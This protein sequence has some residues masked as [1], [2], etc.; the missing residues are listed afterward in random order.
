M[1]QVIKVLL[2]ED[3]RIEARQTQHWL[4]ATKD[5]AFEVEC[6][7]QLKLGLERLAKGGIDIVLL[8]L[9]L[10][11][12]RG[13]E[14]FEKLYSEVPEVPIVVLTGEYDEAIGPSTVAKGAQDYL[15]KQR[16]DSASLTHVL[17]YALARHQAQQGKLKEAVRG[18]TGRVIGFLGA[19]GG[20]GTTTVALNAA[21]ALAMQDKAVIL[22]ELR[23]SFGTL[24]CQL[25][26]QP[27][28]SLRSL[29]DLPADRIG[30]HELNSVLCKGPA[31]VWILFGPK[32]DEDFKEIAPEQADAIIRGLSHM[33]EFVVLDLPSQPSAATQAAASLCHFAAVVTEREPSSV[34]AGKVAVK[35]LHTWGI[36]GNLV[37]GVVLV[38]SI[39]VNRTIYP[40]YS[41]GSAEIRS[42]MGCE[43]V[44]IV[45]SGATENLRALTEGVP[46][47]LL[48][49][50]SDIALS[51]IEIAN[52]LSTDKIVGVHP[53]QGFALLKTPTLAKAS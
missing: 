25:H 15:V 41:M 19:K 35:L 12:S 49:P 18:K 17:R 38:G 47:V 52:R 32:E 22:V 21:V 50:D 28:K 10:P 9:N 3:N 36:K 6:V 4:A 43:I 46:L 5:G 37:G 23:P 30:H 14:T 51:S 8:D 33:A 2:I 42:E 1:S 31:G 39:V 40:N 7:D 26:E 11:D 29:L 24:A 48:Q 45:P 13:L 20:V 27:A 34:L 44:G 53:G 16:A